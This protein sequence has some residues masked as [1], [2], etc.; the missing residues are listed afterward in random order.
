MANGRLS[1]SAVFFFLNADSLRH[2]QQVVPGWIHVLRFEF[3]VVHG[4]AGVD[5]IASRSRLTSPRGTA[6]EGLR[7]F[8][9]ALWAP[10]PVHSRLGS[11]R[12]STTVFCSR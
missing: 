7:S 1:R 5:I 11:W 9:A 12:T 4:H 10:T 3:V 8:P 2:P 6:A